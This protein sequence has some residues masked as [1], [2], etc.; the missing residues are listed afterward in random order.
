MQAEHAAFDAV[1]RP[2]P[3]AF[4]SMLGWAR[5]MYYRGLPRR[6]ETLLLGISSDSPPG[7]TFGDDSSIFFSI[8]DAQ[9]D[10][11]TFEEA[12]ADADEG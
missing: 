2:E 1:E 10:S 5:A 3:A 7:F 12:V 4:A 9:L 6:G 8:K 11:G